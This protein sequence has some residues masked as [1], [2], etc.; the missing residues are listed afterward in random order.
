MARVTR[1]SARTS[2]SLSSE[3]TPLS[4]V[5]PVLSSR[6]ESVAE[7][8]ETPATSEPEDVPLIKTRSASARGRLTGGNKRAAESD[9]DDVEEDDESISKAPAPKRR[10]VSGRVYVSI[11]TTKGKEKV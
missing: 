5:S 3:T 7:E 2:S 4:N 6:P 11:P 10:A 9:N 1:Q 8:P